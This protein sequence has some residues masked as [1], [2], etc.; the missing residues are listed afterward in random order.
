MGVLLYTWLNVHNCGKILL[1]LSHGIQREAH[2]MTHSVQN[3][4]NIMHIIIKIIIELF[5]II[6]V[7]TYCS[8]KLL[9]C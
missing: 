5:M 1:C 9:L 6:K 4:Y 3:N 2:C 7:K 8:K